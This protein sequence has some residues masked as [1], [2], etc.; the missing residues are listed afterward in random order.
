M[1]HPRT[2]RRKQFLHGPS[3]SSPKDSGWI[4]PPNGRIG[5]ILQVPSLFHAMLGVRW[6]SLEF[7]NAYYFGGCFLVLLVSG[8]GIWMHLNCCWVVESQKWQCLCFLYVLFWAKTSSFRFYTKKHQP[9]SR[10]P[11]LCVFSG[12]RASVWAAQDEEWS[13]TSTSNESIV[14]GNLFMFRKFCSPRKQK[15]PRIPPFE[16]GSKLIEKMYRNLVGKTACQP[17]SDS[18]KANGSR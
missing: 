14:S 18:H 2:R 15:P 1:D 12:A 8:R 3:V 9:E 6:I 10:R 17:C 11:F 5:T 13:T 4:G 7:F 16:I